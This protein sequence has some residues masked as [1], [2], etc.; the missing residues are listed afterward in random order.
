MTYREQRNHGRWL[1]QLPGP[2]QFR[3]KTSRSRPGPGKS[4]SMISWLRKVILLNLKSGFDETSYLKSSS[5]DKRLRLVVSR[6]CLGP[7]KSSCHLPGTEILGNWLWLDK[8]ISEIL[9]PLKMVLSSSREIVLFKKKLKFAGPPVFHSG[10]NEPSPQFKWLDNTF[11]QGNI[12][13][14]FEHAH[15]WVYYD[16]LTVLLFDEKF[17]DIS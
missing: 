12:S 5:G 17:L 3:L 11:Q 1:T 14:N 8:V 7:G 16:T 13:Y 4:S 10:W 6:N 15:R 9:R 2:G